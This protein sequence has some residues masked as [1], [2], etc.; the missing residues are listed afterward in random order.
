M[1]NRLIIILGVVLIGALLSSSYYIIDSTEV[2]IVKTFG[3]VS[4]EPVESGIHFKI[5]IVQD[6]VTMN[7]YEKNMDMVENNGNAVKVLTREGL[8]VVIDLSVQYKIDP[9]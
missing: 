6:V 3:K 2:G 1:T 9:K 4:L 5:P 7:I 8:P